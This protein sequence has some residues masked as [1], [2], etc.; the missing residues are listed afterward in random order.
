M[1]RI[2]L[3][4]A[5]TAVEA[6]R[7]KVLTAL[8][9]FGA[10]VISS[11]LFFVYLAPGE[12]GKIIKDIGLSAMVFFGMMI[13]VFGSSV[14]IPKELETKTL[15]TLLAKPVR[16]LEVL[17]GRFAGI[18]AVI[19]LNI[20]IMA[21]IFSAILFLKGG[22]FNYNMLKAILLIF[23]ELGVLSSVTFCLSTF[24]SIGFNIALSFLIYIIGHLVGYFEHIAEHA[25]GPFLEAIVRSLYVIMPNFE[26]FNVKHSII[27]NME[28]PSLYV[29]K[30]FAYA[31]L[32][33]IA[34]L[35]AS[36]VFFNEKEL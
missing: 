28:V 1:K 18:M 14:L 9:I 8:L 21:C 17:I 33:I 26:N 12:E 3:I 30:V 35:S 32:Y 11:S 13:A 22:S 36:Y 29:A 24:T 15:M 31:S 4:A 19:F 25:Q 34:M 16:R 5:N 23:F 27:L 20:I 2:F 7:R 10:L 6:L